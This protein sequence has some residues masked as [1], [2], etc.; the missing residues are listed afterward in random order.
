MDRSSSPLN[1]A[2]VL[3]ILESQSPPNRY[4]PDVYSFESTS[5]PRAVRMADRA[6]LE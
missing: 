4:L 3:G 5:S 6:D 2:R 1:H